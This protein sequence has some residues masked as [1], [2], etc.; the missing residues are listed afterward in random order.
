MSPERLE[1]FEKDALLHKLQDKTDTITELVLSCPNN[2]ELGKKI[3]NFIL[4]DL[5]V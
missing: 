1:Q 2:M 3:R 5:E 4:E